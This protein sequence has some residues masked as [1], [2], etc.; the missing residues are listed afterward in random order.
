[1]VRRL[2]TNDER[3]RVKGLSS[4]SSIISHNSLGHL[5]GDHI[6]SL[7][8]YLSINNNN[9]N[10][11]IEIQAPKKGQ[12]HNSATHFPHLPPS[13]YFQNHDLICP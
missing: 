4:K 11:D 9:N 13:L 12:K 2:R 5:K 7:G 3:P 8:I 10:L 1:M 6:D